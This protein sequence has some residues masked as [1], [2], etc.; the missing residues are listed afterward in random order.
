[1]SDRSE[2]RSPNS[3]KAAPLIW[4]MSPEDALPN[5]VGAAE[6]DKRHPGGQVFVSQ[7]GP[8]VQAARTQLIINKIRRG[9]LIELMEDDAKE[10]LGLYEEQQA[11]LRA[12]AE[13]PTDAEA[14]AKAEQMNAVMVDASA[15]Q[16][17][18]LAAKQEMETMQQTMKEM[19]E[20]QKALQEELKLARKGERKRGDDRPP[21]ADGGVTDA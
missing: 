1:M 7:G 2:L 12:A 9:E 17:A 14:L 4:V 6:N 5:Q 8:P 18:V 10:L 3:K 11:A 15:A 19:Q 21:T 13:N 16:A 20:T